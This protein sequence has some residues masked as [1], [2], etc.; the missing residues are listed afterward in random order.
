VSAVDLA[1]TTDLAPVVDEERWRRATTARPGDPLIALLER[2]RAQSDDLTGHAVDRIL[3][4]IPVYREVVSREDLWLSVSRNLDLNLLVLAERRDVDAAELTVRAAL[5]ARRASAGLPV[6]DVLRAYRVGYLVLWEGLTRLARLEGHGAVDRLLEDA[7]RIWELLDRISSAVAD[8]Y[9][10]RLARQDLDL[11]RRSLRLVAGIE[12]YPDERDRTEA[13]ARELGLDAA[14][15][16]VV[17][18]CNGH[19]RPFEAGGTVVAEQPDRTVV[20][21]QPLTG[22]RSGETT[23]AQRFADE[24][25]AAG[26]GLARHGLAGARRSLVEAQIAHRAA[27]DVDGPVCWRDRWFTCLAFESAAS[28]EPLVGDAVA[29][30]RRSPDTAATIAALLAANGNVSA[31][32]RALHV[33][34]NT[35]AYRLQRLRDVSGLDARGPGGLLAA[36]LAYALA[37][38]RSVDDLHLGRLANPAP[39]PAPVDPAL[40]NPTNPTP[41][42]LGSDEGR[43]GIA[44]EHV[45]VTTPRAGAQ[46]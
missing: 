32:A 27:V 37:Q 5:G 42:S 8:S 29:E 30:L 6:S 45:D 10:E 23:L 38:R 31:A 2:A 7:A 21:L 35:V 22:M 4:A 43:H 19:V 18:V 15:T 28:L 11:R 9:R 16:F 17:G 1:L 14:G 20:V 44:P 41:G 24:G 3:A 34:A 40:W 13:L 33:H 39:D 26:I 36:H 25:V 12:R 46:T